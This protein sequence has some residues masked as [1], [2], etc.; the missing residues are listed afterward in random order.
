MVGKS[1]LKRIDIVRGHVGNITQPSGRGK[2]YVV[3]LMPDPL[4]DI[5]QA[6]PD[7]PNR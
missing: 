4:I 3:T 2:L 6:K 7:H 5:Q 1:R